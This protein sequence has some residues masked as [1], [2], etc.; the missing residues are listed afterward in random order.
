MPSGTQWHGV[1]SG[2][3]RPRLDV[4]VPWRRDYPI[5]SAVLLDVPEPREWIVEALDQELLGDHH[6]VD[7]PARRFCLLRVL[8]KKRMPA[9]VACEQ[10]GMVGH[11]GLQVNFVRT[12]CEHVRGMPWSVANRRAGGFSRTNPFFPL[13]GFPFFLGPY[14]KDGCFFLK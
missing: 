4:R 11:V 1:L 7:C 5:P 3:S 13:M 2:S 10:I 8:V 9:W 12:R 14:M 6:V